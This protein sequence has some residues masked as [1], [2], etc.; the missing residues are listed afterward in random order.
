MTKVDRAGVPYATVVAQG[1]TP[2]MCLTE[3]CT[4]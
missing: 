2:P 4:M 1:P 3:Y